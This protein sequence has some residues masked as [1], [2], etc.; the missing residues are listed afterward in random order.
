[1][2]EVM[3]SWQWTTY[4]PIVVCLVKPREPQ[5]LNENCELKR[6][7]ARTHVYKRKL[8]YSL[9]KTIMLKIRPSET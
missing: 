6:L 7:Y 2:H 4:C 1:M 3:F 8:G 9:S 5:L